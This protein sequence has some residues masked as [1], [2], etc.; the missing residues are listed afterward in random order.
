MGGSIPVEPIAIHIA[1][2]T[3]NAKRKVRMQSGNATI[4][5][6]VTLTNYS[7][8]PDGSFHCEMEYEGPD[9]EESKKCKWTSYCCKKFSEFKLCDWFRSCCRKICCRKQKTQ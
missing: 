3:A 7:I 4:S 1:D 8:D 5:Q 6:E 2:G 9:S